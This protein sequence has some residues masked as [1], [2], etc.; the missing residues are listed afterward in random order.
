MTWRQDRKLIRRDNRQRKRAAV[1]HVARAIEA[2]LYKMLPLRYD[3]DGI[4]ALE[5][6]IE[7]LHPPT[8]QGPLVIRP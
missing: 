1:R 4:Q 5:A 6:A 7:T 2:A 8:V 3:Q